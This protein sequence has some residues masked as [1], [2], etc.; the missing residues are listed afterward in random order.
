MALPIR[1]HLSARSKQRTLFVVQACDEYVSYLDMEH[2]TL[3][4]SQQK[5]RRNV[6]RAV[7]SH[8]CMNET[9]RLPAFAMF[10]IDME[11]RLTLTSE[12][13][14]A[15]TDAA[16]VIV[17]IEFDE[18]EPR[19]HTE[20]T[21]RGDVSMV[22]LLYM[23]KALYV[24]LEPVEGASESCPTEWIEARACLAHM[25]LGADPECEHCKSFQHCVVVPPVTNPR[26]WSLDIE[27]K[28][29]GEIKVKVKRTQL[30]VVSVKGSTLH[31]LQGTTCDPGLIFHWA[32]PN[33]L[34]L[35]QKWLAVYVAL[36]RVRNLKSLRSIG[37]NKKIKQIIERGPP[38]ELMA[39]FEQ[40]FGAK[41][42]QT[43]DLTIECLRKLGWNS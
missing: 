3:D 21:T 9:G 40:Y 41:E 2:K 6:A 25:A 36:S 29:L 16:G 18:R 22:R 20:A 42:K 11:V 43:L 12:R 14:V 33:R 32:L 8:P 23:P 31:V 7:M 24:K 19:K 30:P 35:E 13:Q 27:T 39:Q 1:S 37:L 15:V 5:M 28:E 26:P 10:H 34:M 17:G 4:F 38:E